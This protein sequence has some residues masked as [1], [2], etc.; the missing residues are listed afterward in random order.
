MIRFP[1]KYQQTLWFQPRFHRGCR[2]HPSQNSCHPSS[3]N[4]GS[5]SA[6]GAEGPPA[7]LQGA[8]RLVVQVVEPQLQDPRASLLARACGSRPVSAAPKTEFRGWRQTARFRC[9]WGTIHPWPTSRAPRSS[10]DVCFFFRLPLK[11][12]P[13]W[14]A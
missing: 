13:L 10:R 4:P 3:W 11:K 12:K 5:S 1:C 2:T 8:A 9:L 7:R 14:K 6:E